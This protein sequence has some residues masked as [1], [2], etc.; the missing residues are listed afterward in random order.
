VVLQPVY[1]L[2]KHGTMLLRSFCFYTKK[3]EDG[4]TIEYI[5]LGYKI[6]D[7]NAI[8]GREDIELGGIFKIYDPK[9]DTSKL[10]VEVQNKN[11]I[12]NFVGKVHD[13]EVE[14]NKYI[15]TIIL[16]NNDKIKIKETY[17]TLVYK[18]DFEAS[19]TDIKKENNVQLRT[20]TLD[21]SKQIP[22]AIVEIINI[23]EE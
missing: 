21:R 6:I 11:K 18:N 1:G 20:S 15:F 12:Y 3:Y 14:D 16:N 4:G 10:K 9:I 19:I 5:G 13:I 2:Q 8:A 7:Y 23:V 22:E 17:G